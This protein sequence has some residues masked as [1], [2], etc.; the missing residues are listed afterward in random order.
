M[1]GETMRYDPA[2]AGRA[3]GTLAYAEDP[4]T[5]PAPTQFYVVRR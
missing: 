1:E 3:S 2:H 5:A 4:N